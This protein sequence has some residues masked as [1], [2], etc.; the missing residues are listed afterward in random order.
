L[1]S[2]G[3]LRAFYLQACARCHGED[4]SA[5]AANGRKLK[6]RDFTAERG[7]GGASDEALVQTIRR[8]IFYGLAMP[9]FKKDLSEGEALILVRDVLRKARKGQPIHP[10]GGRPEPAPAQPSPPSAPR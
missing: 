5:R 6:G 4:G 10:E 3:E 9:S 8:G 2:E 1:R 7:L